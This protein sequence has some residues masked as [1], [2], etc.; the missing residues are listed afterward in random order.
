[1]LKKVISLDIQMI[2]SLVHSLDSTLRGTNQIFISYDLIDQLLLRESVQNLL[3]ISLLV[4]PLLE[5]DSERVVEAVKDESCILFRQLS[6]FDPLF[7]L[8]QSLRDD[9]E[10]SVL[11][12]KSHNSLLHVRSLLL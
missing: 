3:R 12:E 7:P 1:M 2:D 9:V 4:L 6:R 5:V 11:E 10:V 8:V